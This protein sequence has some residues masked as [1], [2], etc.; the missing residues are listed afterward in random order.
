LADFLND[1]SCDFL[2]HDRIRS[3]STLAK[4]VTFDGSKYKDLQ[5]TDVTGR[6]SRKQPV[7]TCNESLRQ[8]EAESEGNKNKTYVEPRRSTEVSE[9]FAHWQTVWKH[10]QAKLDAKRQR[11]ISAALKLYPAEQL[12]TAISGYLNSP[13]HTGQNDRNTVYDDIEI[14]LRDAKHIDAGLKFAEQPTVRKWD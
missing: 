2:D 4:F 1:P 11:V 12:C 8:S 6:N 10:P 3:D 5:K 14:F 9:V 7:T 13:H